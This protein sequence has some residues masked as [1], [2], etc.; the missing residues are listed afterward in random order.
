MWKSL[1]CFQ[2]LIIHLLLIQ[3]NVSMGQLF[4]ENLAYVR[5]RI[6]LQKIEDDIATQIAA[7]ERKLNQDLIKIRTFYNDVHAWANSAMQKI[8]HSQPEVCASLLQ[9]GSTPFN[10][11]V[12]MPTSETSGYNLSLPKARDD[13]PNNLLSAEATDGDISSRMQ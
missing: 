4:D 6:E 7:I 11:S 13:H 3:T 2:L 10:I 12:I 8:R 5:D 1:H 9:T